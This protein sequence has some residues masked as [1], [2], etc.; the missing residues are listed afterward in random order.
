MPKMTDCLDKKYV[1]AVFFVK[2]YFY[3]FILFGRLEAI[4]RL[5]RV[6]FSPIKS[7]NA[8]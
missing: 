5:E 4:L 7:G 6:N 3:Y 2:M 8:F 1:P